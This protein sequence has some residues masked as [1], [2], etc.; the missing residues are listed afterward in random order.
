MEGKGAKL[1][2]P[3]PPRHLIAL[4]RTC[5]EFIQTPAPLRYPHPTHH[6]LH[7]GSVSAFFQDDIDLIRV[8]ACSQQGAPALAL[9]CL[10]DL[11]SVHP[12]LYCV[13]QMQLSQGAGNSRM[14][15]FAGSEGGWAKEGNFSYLEVGKTSYGF[16]DRRCPWATGSLGG[17]R[18]TG[19]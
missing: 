16:R 17:G 4:L 19:G 10:L 5:C 13:L 14:G 2:L 9:S 7:S 8:P 1:T 3:F 15:R 6:L 12:P 18:D 11:A